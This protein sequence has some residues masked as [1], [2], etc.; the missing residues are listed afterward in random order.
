MTNKCTSFA[1]HFDGHADQSLQPE[2]ISHDCRSRATLDAI[3]HHHWASI[4]P[5]SPQR[6][7]WSLILA[8]K[9]ELWHCETTQ[10]GPSTQPIEATSC[11]ERSDAMIQ[12]EELSYLSSH[13]TLTAD[14]NLS[15][16]HERTKHDRIL[17]VMIVNSC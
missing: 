1:G 9:I 12:A 4:C 16:Y 17:T 13:Q 2:H 15:R 8:K 11:I 6:T 14:K 3:R 7:S 5:V 10:N